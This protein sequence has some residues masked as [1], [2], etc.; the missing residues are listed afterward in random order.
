MN[1]HHGTTRKVIVH[2]GVAVKF[3]KDERGRRGNLREAELWS[4]YSD[5][6]ERSR[7]LCPVLWCAGDG[8]V[9][10]MRQAQPVGEDFDYSMLPNWDYL[11]G[12]DDGDPF[13]PKALDWGILDGHVVAVDYAVDV[14]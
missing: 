3:A 12:D 13:E 6:P 14:L 11:G 9:L 7:M 2:D 10:I 1:E 4:R 8:A 5:H